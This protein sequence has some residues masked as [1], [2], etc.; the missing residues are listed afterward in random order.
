MTAPGILS[1]DFT[2]KII[3]AVG[4]ALGR[5]LRYLVEGEDNRI[6]LGF[7][8][9]GDVNFD[10]VVNIFDI[11]LVSSGW[12]TTND[13]PDANGDNI[14]NIFDINLISSNWNNNVGIAIART[15]AAING[16]VGIRLIARAARDR[17][18]AKTSGSMIE[19]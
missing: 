17:A 4:D 3:P 18:I 15:G 12:N 11:N 5:K 9:D 2:T 8:H 13:R 6:V 1:G 14:V 19:H 7:S 16:V 10:G